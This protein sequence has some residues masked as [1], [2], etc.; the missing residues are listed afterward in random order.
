ML[1]MSLPYYNIIMKRDKGIRVPEFCLPE[2]FEF[3]NYVDGDEYEWARIETA[4]L[5]FDSVDEGLKYF[6]E[7]YRP[8][9]KELYKRMFFIQ[10]KEGEKVGTL[11]LWREMI[12]GKEVH[13]FHWF[14][15]IKEYQGMGL[16]KALAYEGVRRFLEQYGEV[17]IY[18]HTQTW[19]YTAVIIYNKVGFEIKKDIRFDNCRNDYADALKVLRNKVD[20]WVFK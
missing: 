15:I 7:N 13:A 20:S 10:T 12:G 3:V 19:S 2:Q 14:G 18:L 1:D 5:E 6:D 8:Y 9:K 17:D 16:G 4:V 11:T